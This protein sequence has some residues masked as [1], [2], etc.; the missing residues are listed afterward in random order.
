MI[1]LPLAAAR[2]CRVHVRQ[3][4]TALSAKIVAEMRRRMPAEA[5]TAEATPHHLVLTMDDFI[6]FGRKA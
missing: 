5:L 3:V 1:V 6:R 4:S 2:H